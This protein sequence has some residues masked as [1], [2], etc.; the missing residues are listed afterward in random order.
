MDEINYIICQYSPMIGSDYKPIN[1]LIK[2][3]RVISGCYE[4]DSDMIRFFLQICG[5]GMDEEN[6]W[7]SNRD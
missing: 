2:N 5:T 4:I 1:N 3:I 6:F 7:K